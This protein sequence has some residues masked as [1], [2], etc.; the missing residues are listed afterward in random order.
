MFEAVQAQALLALPGAPFEL[1][2]WLSPRVAPDC[3]L[4]S[5]LDQQGLAAMA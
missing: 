4:F 5:E 3:R 1:A 2:R